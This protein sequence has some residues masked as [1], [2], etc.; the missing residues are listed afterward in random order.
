MA[1]ERASICGEWFEH[2]RRRVGC[3]ARGRDGARGARG[4][5]LSAG[6]MVIVVLAVLST[7]VIAFSSS[8]KAEERSVWLF[9][10]PHYLLYQ[11]MV[12]A[13]NKERRPGIELRLLANAALERRMMSAFFA[14]TPSADFIEVERR[15]VGR[16][17]SGPLESVGFVDL[18]ELMKR[19][20]LFELIN[21]PSF[22]PWASRGRVFGIPHDVHP[23][24]LAY[25]ADIVEAAGIDVSKIETW[26]DYI[27]VMSPL[28]ADGDGD[29]EPDR[30]LLNM[31]ETQGDHLELLMLQAGGGLFDDAG[32]L[33]INSAE[34]ARVLATIVRWCVGPGRI[35]A[36]APNFSAAGNQLKLS[37]HVVASFM[38]DWM[39]DVWK[40]DLPQLEGK[41]KLMPMPAWDRGGLR[42]SVWGGTMLGIPKT[43]VKSAEDLEALWTFAKHLYLSEDLARSTFEEGGII[44]PVKSH[45]D[46]PVFDR[47]DPYFAGQAVGRMFIELAPSVPRRTSSPYNTMALARVNNALVR[48]AESARR[49][50]DVEPE[51]L[52]ARAKEALAGAEADVKAQMERNV[53]HRG[54]DGSN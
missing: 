17:F 3:A 29:G 4:A 32:R 2:A 1:S 35:A 47:K 42:T 13:W 51:W 39:C 43:A 15:M 23:V 50:G 9:A 45:W 26:D 48:L 30:Y 40:H 12:E 46:D 36:E 54:G 7:V 22:G 25:R 41:V 53:F 44:T 14:G 19:D 8:P 38:P 28:M 27:R 10:R 21:E 31:W 24:M 49:S 18:T 11:P 6:A 33:I 16:A 34:N 5:M 37:G 20:G 52:L